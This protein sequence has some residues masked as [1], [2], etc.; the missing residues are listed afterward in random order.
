MAGIRYRLALPHWMQQTAQMSGCGGKAA[1][2][3]RQRH[4]RRECGIGLAEKCAGS[5][6][7]RAGAVV[8]VARC[9]SEVS[10]LDVGCVCA[11]VRAH[12]PLPSRIGL[13]HSGTFLM[14]HVQQGRPSLRQG[15]RA[16]VGAS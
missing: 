12:C 9:A 13:N 10:G 1:N 5:I 14:P 2:C 15:V 11:A 3:F 6:G 7:A 4:L 16:G 8:R